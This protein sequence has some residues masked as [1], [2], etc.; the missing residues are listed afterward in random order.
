MDEMTDE[1]VRALAE[2]EERSLRRAAEAE[3]ERRSRSMVESM[4]FWRA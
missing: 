2:L 1:D 4:R 3:I